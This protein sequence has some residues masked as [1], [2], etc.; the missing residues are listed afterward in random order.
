MKHIVFAFLIATVLLAC[1]QND[2][3]ENIQPEV[4]FFAVSAEATGEE[5]ELRRD[6]FEDTKIYLLF[7]DTL[8]VRETPTLSGEILSETQ[9]VNFFWNMTSSGDQLDSLE[10]EYYQDMEQKRAA[11]QFLQ[12]EVFNGALPELFYPYS[13]LPLN[14]CTQFVTSINMT[15]GS[16]YME[17]VDVVAFA[18]FQCLAVALGDIAH[19]SQEERDILAG[20]VTGK[21]VSSYMDLIPDEE[22]ETFYSYS[23]DYYNVLGFIVPQPP[24]TCGFL[25]LSILSYMTKEDDK[26]A[27]VEKVFELTEEEFRATYGAYPAVIAKMEEVVKILNKYGVNIYQ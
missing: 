16:E 5:A 20:Q 24:Q 23:E 21:I 19:V 7:N 9:V 18:G 13:V 1:S 3:F 2:W 10:F 12:E 6:F 27:F 25:E 17:A 22:F 26:S 4:N 11:T 15:D 14:H 8:G